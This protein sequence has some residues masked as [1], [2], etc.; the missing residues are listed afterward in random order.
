MNL[1]TECSR[2]LPLLLQEP[3]Q[4]AMDNLDVHDIHFPY[5]IREDR[6][7]MSGPEPIDDSRADYIASAWPQRPQ[8]PHRPQR[9]RVASV[10]GEESLLGTKGAEKIKAMPCHAMPCHAVKSCNMTATTRNLLHWSVLP[11]QTQMI[12]GRTPELAISRT[13]EN[14]KNTSLASGS[15]FPFG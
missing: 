11:H 7:S 10:S 6:R 3:I 9:P 5:I 12:H 8:R 14:R 2:Y 13:P 1:S 4:Y 15:L